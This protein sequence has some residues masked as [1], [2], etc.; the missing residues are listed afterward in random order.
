MTEHDALK[1]AKT[2]QEYCQSITV[3]CAGCIFNK[4]DING[5]FWKGC[6]IDD[7]DHLPETWELEK[8]QDEVE[9][10]ERE[11]FEKDITCPYDSEKCVYAPY[12]H[13]TPCSSCKRYK[14]R[15]DF[16]SQEEIDGVLA[17]LHEI[18]RRGEQK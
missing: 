15:S 10:E 5:M 18:D 6:L 11:R 16:I 14:G 8:I 12:P 7:P 9:K 13:P 1:A 3:D 2:L 4:H 17:D